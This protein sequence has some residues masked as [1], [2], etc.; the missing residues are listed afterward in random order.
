MIPSCCYFRVIY[1]LD[2][3]IETLELLSSGQSE[4]RTCNFVGWKCELLTNHKTISSLD[5]F[6]RRSRKQDVFI[7]S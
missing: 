7:S 2:M 3:R 5:I 4:M 6:F 1:L